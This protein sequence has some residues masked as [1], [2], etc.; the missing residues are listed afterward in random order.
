MPLGMS[1]GPGGRYTLAPALRTI[2]HPIRPDD[3]HPLVVAVL[4]QP[5]D[6]IAS[7]PFWGFDNGQQGDHSWKV[8]GSGSPLISTDI[9]K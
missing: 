3:P 1:W 9:S 2:R 5:V 7:D 4:G 6:E 8:R